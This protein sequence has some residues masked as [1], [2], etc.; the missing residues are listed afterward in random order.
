MY[1]GIEQKH[2][3]STPNSKSKGLRL[4]WLQRYENFKFKYRV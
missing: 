4:L 1:K 3:I 2:S